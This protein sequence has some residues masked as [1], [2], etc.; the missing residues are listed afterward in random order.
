MRDVFG[1]VGGWIPDIPDPRDRL[2]AFAPD[3]SLP[4]AHKLVIPWIRDQG[5]LGSCTAHAGALMIRYREFRQDGHAPAPS[6][7]GLYFYTRA[8]QGTIPY[9]SGASI[10]GTMKAASKHGFCDEVLWPYKTELYRAH[11]SQE[12]SDACAEHRLG[13]KAY[14][15]VQRND[16]RRALADDYPVAFGF[17]VFDSFESREVAKAGKVPMPNL[18]KEKNRGGHALVLTGYDDATKLFTARNSWG[19]KWGDNG[20]CYFPYDFINDRRLCSDFWTV[21]EV[22]PLSEEKE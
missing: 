7:L 10:R 21:Y 9:D 5:R 13:D 12:A 14:A 11:P 17:S 6:E 3:P 19:E 15:R 22:P 1:H 18:R 20:D 4:E 8:D 2:M 16:L